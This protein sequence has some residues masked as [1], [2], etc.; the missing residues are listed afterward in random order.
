MTESDAA[1]TPPPDPG[2]PDPGQPDP[3]QPSAPIPARALFAAFFIAGISGFG[4]VLPFAR[5]VIVERRRWLTP[6]EFADLFALCQFMP[7]PNIVNFAAVLGARNAGLRGA[8]ASLAGLLA[9]PVTIAMIAGLAFARYGAIPRV[10]DALAAL[11][12]GASGLILATALRI[13]AASVRAP[14]S[15]FVIALGFTLFGLLELRLPIV[16]AITL[17]VAILLA[18]RRI[19]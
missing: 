3:G 12:A 6:A 19:R 8:L 4:G 1:A 11:A 5:R 18:A 13:A 14:S 16:L 7:G 10:H 2:P 9:A 15:L 17:P